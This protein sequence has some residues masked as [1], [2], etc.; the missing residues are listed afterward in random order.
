MPGT[1]CDCDRACS[2]FLAFAQLGKKKK[3]ELQRGDPRV[4]ENDFSSQRGRR[5]VTGTHLINKHEKGECN[6]VEVVLA[7]KRLT[8]WVLREDIIMEREL[9]VCSGVRGVSSV[10]LP[11]DKFEKPSVLSNPE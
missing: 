7:C 8:A 10:E 6:N 5:K 11:P 9:D 2:I 3:K 4:E 1:F